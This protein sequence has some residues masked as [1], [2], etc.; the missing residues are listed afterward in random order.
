M[1]RTSNPSVFP[2]PAIIP[3]QDATKTQE[4]KSPNA[5]TLGAPVAIER[6]REESALAPAAT[7]GPMRQGRLGSLPDT[8]LAHI[9]AFLPTRETLAV[10]LQVCR[11]SELVVATALRQGAERLAGQYVRLRGDGDAL[12][13]EFGA[14]STRVD[15]TRA[16][17]ARMRKIRAEVARLD[18]D[19]VRMAD[20]RRSLERT[21]EAA[22]V[23]GSLPAS[24]PRQPD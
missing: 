2:V 7:G 5:L 12:N 21:W 6:S 23:K 4:G 16:P 13:R 22:G 19:I 3:S 8:L 18:D 14:L 10:A 15:G 11:G 24:D 20:A 9:L 17:V 1:R